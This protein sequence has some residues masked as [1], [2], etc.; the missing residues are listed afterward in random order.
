MNGNGQMEVH[1]INTGFPY[2]ITESFMNF[3][4]DLTHVPVNYGHAVPMHDQVFL[5]V[6]S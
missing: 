4:D 2:T 6:K 3:F 5:V 1:Y